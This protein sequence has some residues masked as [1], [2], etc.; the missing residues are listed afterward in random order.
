MADLTVYRQ[1]F[2]ITEKWTYLNHAAVGPLSR[3]VVQA[4]ER[5]LHARQEGELDLE[6]WERTREGTRA[7]AARLLNA[8]PEEIAFAGATGDGLDIAASILP[9][10]PGDNVILCDV[11]FPANVYPW[12]HLERKGVEVRIVPHDGGG[13]TPERLA[14]TMD[15]RTRVVTVSSVQFLSGFCADLP[16]LSRLCKENGTFFVVDAIQSLGAVPLDVRAAGVDILAANGAKWLMAPIGTSILYVR[17]EL[18][19]ELPPSR[20]YYVAYTPPE[21]YLEYSRQLRDDARR[22]EVNSPNVIGI[23]GLRAALSLLLE[24]GIE[25]IHERILDL[26]DRLIAGLDALGIEMLTPRRRERRAGIVTIRT[27]DP[28]G[29]LARLKEA[30]VVIALR[31]GYLRISPHFYNTPAEIDRLLELLGEKR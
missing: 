2:P 16:A 19:R 17:R 30:G 5:L 23:Y 6:E 11:E 24:V 3:R 27:E 10:Q 22:F 14:A 26:T 13:L 15:R 7:L 29:D 9:L 4:I 31:E 20:G 18:A 25:R 21:P 28:A 8:T 1:E 12:L